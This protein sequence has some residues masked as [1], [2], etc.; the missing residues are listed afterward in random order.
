MFD[1]F[2]ISFPATDVIAKVR[3]DSRLKK[4]ITI[5]IIAAVIIL[6]AAILIISLQNINNQNKKHKMVYSPSSKHDRSAK[7][8]KASW[9]M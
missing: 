6:A 9:S 2:K 3:G 4:I 5:L 7:I 8:K 1:K